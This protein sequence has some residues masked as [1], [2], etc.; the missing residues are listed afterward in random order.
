MAGE[1]SLELGM[2]TIDCADPGRLATFW[3]AALGTSVEGDYG[4]FVFLA[5]AARGRRV[6]RGFQRVAEPTPGKNRVHV[7]LIAKDRV[8]EVQRLVE[9]GATQQYDQ[10]GVV[11]GLEWT[12]LADPEGNA[13]CVGQEV[14]EVQASPA[15]A[16]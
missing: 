12:T 1:L 8:G 2:V 9:L 14:D 13:F 4:D 10:L 6:A 3:S 15:G 7:D 16:Q 5:P 11:P